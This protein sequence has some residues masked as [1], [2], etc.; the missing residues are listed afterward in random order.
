MLL[1]DV[2]ESPTTTYQNP[3][4]LLDLYQMQPSYTETSMISSDEIDGFIPIAVCNSTKILMFI[5]S[6]K[7]ILKMNIQNKLHFQGV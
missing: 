1:I 5:L 6:K 3:P 7:N 4:H 2:S